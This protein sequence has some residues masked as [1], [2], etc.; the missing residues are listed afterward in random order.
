M[1]RTSCSYW[2]TESIGCSSLVF[3][4]RTENV[5]SVGEVKLILI[6]KSHTAAVTQHLSRIR[7]RIP[8]KSPSRRIIKGVSNWN[9]RRKN[10][11]FYDDNDILYP[12]LLVLSCVLPFIVVI[13]L[14]R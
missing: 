13:S 8:A 11:E 3:G 7:S 14:S 10:K 5:L 12:I 9:I 1:R 4:M 6:W 2:F